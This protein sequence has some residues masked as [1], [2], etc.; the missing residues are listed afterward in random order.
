MIRPV[1]IRNR[2]IGP[3]CK[4]FIIA[5]ACINHEGDIRIAERMVYI[6]HAVGADC[7]KFQIH[8]LENEMQS[9][10]TACAI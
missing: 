4:P 6:A 10:P 8:V 2:P 1:T 7:I 3:D 5:E 9:A